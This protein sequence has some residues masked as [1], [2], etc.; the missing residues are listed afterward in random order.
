MKKEKK[1]RKSNRITN[2]T[3]HAAYAVLEKYK[4]GKAALEQRIIDNEQWWK[5][6]HYDEK[7]KDSIATGWLFNTIINKH[8]DAMDNIPEATC[9]LLYTARCV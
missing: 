2:D 3:V 1:G 5:L 4:S 7:D 9:C 6:R 8:A